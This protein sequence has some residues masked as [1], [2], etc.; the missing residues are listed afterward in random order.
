VGPRRLQKLEV[1]LKG[2]ETIW[3]GPDLTETYAAQRA[4]CVKT[5][6]GLCQREH[7]ADRWV[8]ATAIWLRIPLVAHD[9]IFVNVKDLRPAHELDP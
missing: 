7:E 8:A 5:G 1:E 2:A 3:P 4:W 9:A 6:H